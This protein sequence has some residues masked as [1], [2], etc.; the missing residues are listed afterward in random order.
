[1]IIYV[2]YKCVNDKNIIINENYADGDQVI[3]DENYVNDKNYVDE[4][5]IIYENYKEQ[6]ADQ[7]DTLNYRIN[8]FLVIN[9][10]S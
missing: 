10:I 6:E 7:S 1:M 4:N 3:V 2:N 5:L 9:E 8:K